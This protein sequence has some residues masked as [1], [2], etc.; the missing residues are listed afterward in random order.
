MPQHRFLGPATKRPRQMQNQ[1]I[2]VAEG[3][4]TEFAIAKSRI[5]HYWP[6][7]GDMPK[8]QEEAIAPIDFWRYPAY[9]MYAAQVMRRALDDWPPSRP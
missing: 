9:P 5:E 2:G 3:L 7:V 8:R 1:S 6:R 4:D